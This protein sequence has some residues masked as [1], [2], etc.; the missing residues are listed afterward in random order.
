MRIVI[1]IISLAALVLS[2]AWLAYQPGFDSLVSAVTCLGAFLASFLPK[3]KAPQSESGQS[4]NVSAGS[5]CIQ[6]GRDVKVERR[7]K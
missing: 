7:D 3:R 6:A 4:Q 1:R 5:I 2:L